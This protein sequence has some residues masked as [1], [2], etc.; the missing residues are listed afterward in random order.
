AAGSGLQH[1]HRGRPAH[2]RCDSPSRGGKGSPGGKPDLLPRPDPTAPHP[3]PGPRD[4]PPGVP[5]PPP[6]RSPP[7]PP[8]PPPL[9]P[10]SL[11]PTTT[12][13]IPPTTTTSTSTSS[14]S[15]TFFPTTT[16]GDGLVVG[17]EACDDGNAASGDGCSATCTV[18]HGFNCVGQPS[19]CG[20]TCGDGLIAP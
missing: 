16:C 13:T 1:L 12:T 10:R 7:G 4:S 18:E 15:S 11:P 5:R 17:N 14:T 3:P 20:S 9:S 19:V 2:A 8:P 6:P